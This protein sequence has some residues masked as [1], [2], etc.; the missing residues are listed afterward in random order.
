MASVVGQPEAPARTSSANLVLIVVSTAHA[1]THMY[2]ALLP[3]TFPFI[4]QEFGI[5]YT[6]LGAMMGVTSL[7]AGLLQFIW[8]YANRYISSKVLI[9]GGNILM[10]VSML[11]GGIAPNF[12]QFAL[13]RWTAAIVTSPQ[14][15]V[16]NSLIAD[17]F[18]RQA[19]GFALAV[20]YAGGNAGT[21]LV[22][23]TATLLIVGLGWRQTLA[24]FAIPCIVV[25]V[26]VMAL[27]R[28]AGT[29]SQQDA[30]AGKQA[31]SLAAETASLFRNRTFVLLMGASLVAAGGK[32]LGIVLT[33]MPAYLSDP[34]RGLGLPPDAVGF[35]YTLLL[36]GSVVGPLALGRLSD[37][38]GVRRPIIVAAYLASAVSIT[39]IAR[40]AGSSWYLP[41]MLLIF[42][43]TVY[44]ESPMIQAFL[45]DGVKAGSRDIMFGTF[46]AVGFGVSSLWG[47]AQGFLVDT[48]GFGAMFIAMAVSYVLGAL[49]VFATREEPRE[50]AAEA[51]AR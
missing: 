35:H 26:L 15:P 1:M 43:C 2:A 23:V 38:L 21:L 33:F 46:F 17:H 14:H 8:G 49:F 29:R 12:L 31:L 44:A 18:G 37:R 11:L 39:V 51:A 6:A 5:N 34:V 41:V 16:G 48:F 4:I 9:G 42:G 19:R 25:G 13:A 45:S 47:V 20:N 7:A 27:I 28:E 40:L 22:P 32:G 3:L 36:I 10:G 24:I 30:K 50:P